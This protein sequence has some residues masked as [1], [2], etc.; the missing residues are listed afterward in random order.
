MSDEFK[1]VKVWRTMQERGKTREKT[2][3]ELMKF[4][5]EMGKK[6]KTK[7][8]LLKLIIYT[9][10]I[11]LQDAADI[12]GVKRA[13]I[14]VWIRQLSENK[15]VEI[16]ETTHPNPTVR[17]KREILEKFR[18]QIRK[19]PDALVQEKSGKDTDETIRESEMI[20]EEYIEP[21]NNVE[22]KKSD[23]SQVEEARIYE[24]PEELKS[25]TTYLVLGKTP[26]V[27]IKLFERQV[28]VGYM[29]LVITR[30]NPRHMIKRIKTENTKFV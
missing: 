24:V 14:D 26:Q 30:T 11:R 6:E 18:K 5:K 19:L 20:Q 15:L 13:V 10:G 8:G 22:D 2:L 28:G 3:Q 9:E 1:D 16:E 7:K 21:E 12:L 25:K 23:E 29:G 27:C 17:P 4:I